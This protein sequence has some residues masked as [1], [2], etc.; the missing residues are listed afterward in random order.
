M[1]RIISV[2]S[3]TVAVTALIAP[4]SALALA[5]DHAHEPGTEAH[6]HVG[7]AVSCETLATPP[8]AGLPDMDRLKMSALRQEITALNTPELAI[9]AGFNPALG[10][11][12]GMGVHYVKSGGGPD[13]V[14]VN[15]PNHLM[16]AEMDGTDK[17]VGAAYAFVDAI[18]TDAVVPFDSDLANWHDHPQFAGD[19]QTLHMLHIWFIPSSN[20]PFAG[21]NFWLPYR[22]AGVAIPSSCWMA[23]DADALRIQTVSFGLVPPRLFGRQAEAAGPS[24]ERIEM[25][26]ALDAAA[27][28]VDHDA[29]VAAADVFIA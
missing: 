14:D 3:V 17:L 18:D 21:L 25:I 7:A 6:S 10:D 29:W 11:I 13:D 28:A 5:Q 27:I 8:W 20:G 4:R 16:F 22:T 9:A 12:P 26:A 23:D 19:G 24:P 2:L 15:A 1:S